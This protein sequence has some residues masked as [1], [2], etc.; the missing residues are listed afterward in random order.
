MNNDVQIMIAISFS[1]LITFTFHRALNEKRASNSLF[2]HTIA[3]TGHHGFL[4]L[5]LF[6]SQ[7]GI[8]F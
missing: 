6:I 7:R 1:L 3:D 4:V 2:Q 5:A 8:L